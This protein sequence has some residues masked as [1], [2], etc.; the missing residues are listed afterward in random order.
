MAL[1][2]IFASSFGGIHAGLALL[3]QSARI[4]ANPSAWGGAPPAPASRTA[5]HDILVVKLSAVA[6]EGSNHG[7]GLIQT[8]VSTAQD[9]T[10]TVQGS[11]GTDLVDGM[12]DMLIAQRMIEANARMIKAE[13]KVLVTM[14][15]IGE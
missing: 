2:D 8:V 9:P 6:R 7:G 5:F 13:D 10:V 15:H 11:N 14:I 12:L 3:D 4:A 1:S